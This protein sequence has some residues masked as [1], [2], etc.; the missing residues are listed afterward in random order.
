LTQEARETCLC[1]R[2]ENVYNPCIT[3]ANYS[4]PQ[5]VEDLSVPFV[6]LGAANMMVRD[7]IL[8][9]IAQT[10]DRGDFLNG[11]AVSE[12]EHRF[13][14]Y[15]GRNHCV[16]VSSG[17]DA[18]RLS[19]LA[20][21]MASGSGVIVP[22]STF[23]ATFEAVIQAGGAPV[24]VDVSEVDY[25]IDADQAEAAAAA[26]TSHIV[27]VHLYGQMAD[28]RRV[29]GLAET[30]G[31]KIVED[32]CQAHGASR[33]GVL[34]GSAGQAAA[35]SFYPPKN[36][37]AMGDAGALVT[38]DEELASRARALRV[39][40]ETS[41]YHHEYVGYTARLDTIQAIVLLEKL[42]FL[43]EWNGRRQAAARFYTK[44]LSGLE[45]LR[46]PAEPA[47]SASVWHLYVVRVTE[48]DDLGSFLAARGIQT[49][50]HYPEPVH[51]SP[52]YRNLGFAAGD[53]PVA[54]AVSREGLSLPLYPG[55][56]EAQ[57]EWVCEA[58]IEYFRVG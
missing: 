14:E 33:D 5:P 7:R 41:K 54:E 1:W 26:G 2:D 29:S 22:A 3:P 51:L 6:D 30:H 23:A 56:T 21:G 25:N 9:R 24:V 43:N 40:G 18:L 46:L 12:F 35:F 39:H 42:P 8:A 44:S 36:L 27:P 57:L 4:Q 47:G 52:A 15:S 28:M 10:I 17:L 11:T 31:L 13:A 20:S 16:A 53:F 32:A 49:G 38:D 37:G 48:P 34:A 45:G 58:I 55:I 19:L 50:R